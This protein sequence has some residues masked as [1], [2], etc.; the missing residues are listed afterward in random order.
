MNLISNCSGCQSGS[1]ISSGSFSTSPLTT[2]GSGRSIQRIIA[3]SGNYL[4]GSLGSLAGMPG[5]CGLFQLDTSGPTTKILLDNG[6]E[7]GFPALIKYSTEIFGISSPRGL[8][9]IY[10]T[11]GDLIKSMGKISNWLGGA[12][13]A[14][15]H[16][17]IAYILRFVTSSTPPVPYITSIAL[18]TYQMI[19]Y[20]FPEDIT[21]L[22]SSVIPLTMAIYSDTIFIGTSV[23][24]MLFSFDTTTGKFTLLDRLDFYDS[25]SSLTTATGDIRCLAANSSNGDIW[26]VVS[27]DPTKPPYIF[28]YTSAGVLSK[29]AIFDDEYIG[30]DVYSM[31]LSY[32]NPTT[33]LYMG[34]RKASDT[35]CGAEIVK[36]D[37]SGGGTFGYNWASTR[38]IYGE[39]AITALYEDATYIYAGTAPNAILFKVQISNSTKTKLY[40]FGTGGSI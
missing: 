1:S 24:P 11:S 22:T 38:N 5:R 34:I 4:Y 25:T 40:T 37:S 21:D 8:A 31:T 16:N 29:E 28:K 19:Q 13:D 23:N 20:E 32:A 14:L 3:G 10:D 26:G 33:T 2:F 15:V 7:C 39:R 18:S 9:L 17:G 6:G 36:W 12:T 30:S 35:F 27:G